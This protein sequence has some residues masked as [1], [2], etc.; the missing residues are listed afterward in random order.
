MKIPFVNNRSS[1]LTC[2]LT[3]H[4]AMLLHSRSVLDERSSGRTINLLTNATS[5]VANM[6]SGLVKK[7]N[8]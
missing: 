1:R 3:P 5:A 2:E 6:P 8:A 7:W 4:M